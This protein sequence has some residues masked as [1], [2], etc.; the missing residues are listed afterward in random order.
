MKCHDLEEGRNNVF[1]LKAP[2]L[3]RSVALLILCLI[4]TF[5]EE[6]RWGR[7]G[8]FFLVIGS[9]LSLTL[10]S[11]IKKYIVIYNTFSLPYDFA[12]WRQV[13]CM[14]W[15]TLTIPRFYTSSPTDYLTRHNGLQVLY[16]HKFRHWHRLDGYIASGSPIQM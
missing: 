16:F 1:C 11:R 2:L 9:L 15:H 13:G 5:I 6:W 8:L 10:Q 4:K 14:H 7:K 12:V 3:S